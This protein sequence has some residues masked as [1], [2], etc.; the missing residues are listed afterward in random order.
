[1]SGAG[2]SVKTSH[3]GTVR[4]KPTKTG[5]L[6]LKVSEKGYI[7]SAPAPVPVAS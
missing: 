2:K 4:L 1:V 3:A 7:R 6:V 5:T